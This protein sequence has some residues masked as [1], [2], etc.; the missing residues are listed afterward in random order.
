MRVSVQ[1]MVDRLAAAQAQADRVARQ[2]AKA[3]RAEEE[4]KAE[5]GFG[6]MDIVSAL[7]TSLGRQKTCE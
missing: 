7:S 6:K 4:Q 3:A 5:V 2:A 1:A